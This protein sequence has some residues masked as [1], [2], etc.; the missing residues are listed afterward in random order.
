VNELVPGRLDEPLTRS[1]MAKQAGVA[2]TTLGNWATRDHAALATVAVPNGDALY[3]WR[4][5]LDFC[6]ANPSL[7]ATRQV[8]EQ[9]RKHFADD[10]SSRP[11]QHPS[12]GGA[13]S[14]ARGPSVI[15]GAAP[16]DRVTLRS[17]LQDLKI[18]VDTNSAVVAAAAK[19]AEDA[20]S[21]QAAL[22]DRLNV[23]EVAMGRGTGS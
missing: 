13:A 18:Q 9:Y 3:T 23:L 16:D 14:A 6:A 21:S 4:S 1:A 11:L 17:A 19:L 2:S 20:A 22:V 7:H 15:A 12:S 8:R 10:P 5:L